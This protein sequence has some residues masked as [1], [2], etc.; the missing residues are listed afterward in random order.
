MKL[1]EEDLMI[2]RPVKVRIA[3]FISEPL[4]MMRWS[5]FT[6]PILG[7]RDYFEK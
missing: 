5:L 4:R 3:V 2:M 6:M 1:L 7:I